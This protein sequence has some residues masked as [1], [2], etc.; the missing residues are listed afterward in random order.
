MMT[1][2]ARVLAVTALLW[3]AAA[4]AHDDRL[5]HYEALPADSLEQAVSNLKS[6]NQKLA[7]ILQQEDISAENM[8]QI[9]ELTYTLEVAL[10]RLQTELAQTADVL[11]EVHLGSETMDYDRVREEGARYLQV[12][13]QLLGN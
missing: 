1:N 9:H 11:E 13:Q 3:G 4:T 8:V 10:E 6:H 2:I 12:M 7:T 5:E